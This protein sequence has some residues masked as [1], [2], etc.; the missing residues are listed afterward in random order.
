VLAN[1]LIQSQNETRRDVKAL[2]LQSILKLAL[3]FHA[4]ALNELRICKFRMDSIYAQRPTHS[5][6]SMLE[7][8]NNSGGRVSV[9]EIIRNSID[10]MRNTCYHV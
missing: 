5:Y 10:D 3:D 4:A 8:L 6:Q 7:T 9:H 1:A 2:L